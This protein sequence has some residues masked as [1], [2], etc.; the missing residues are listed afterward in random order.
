MALDIV[1][2]E[3]FVVV[4]KGRGYY[5]DKTWFIEQFLQ[6]RNDPEFFRVPHR[7]TLFTRPRR[8]GKT[9]F[10]SMLAAFFDRKMESQ[11][12]ELFA[13]LKVMS[14]ERLCQEWMNKY[15]VLFL[16]MKR[17]GKPTFSESMK[18]LKK[19]ISEV[20]RLHAA[21]VLE[22]QAVDSEDKKS[23]QKLCDKT[24]E[25]NDL[26]D[27]P[28]LLTKIL[29]AHHGKK[30][31]LLI[32]EYDDPLSKSFYHKYYNE[33]LPIMQSFYGTV[34]KG[35][36]HLNF[37]IITGILRVGIES[38][39]SDANNVTNYDIA[40]KTK[41]DDL[42]GFN[43]QEVDDVLAGAGL[44]DRRDE[45][46]TWYDGYHFGKREDIYCP[47]SVMSCAEDMQTVPELEPDDYWVN[48]SKN[49]ILKGFAGHVP[50]NI[51]KHMQALME[52]K[53]ISASINQSMDYD[54][55]N[56][57]IDNFW[58]L[59]FLT[60][61]L[62]GSNDIE[63][64]YNEH[65]KGNTLLAI[66]N[67]EVYSAFEREIKKW[68]GQ[69]LKSDDQKEFLRKFWAGDAQGLEK[70]L[71][72]KLMQSASFRDY[73][74]KE[75]FYHALLLGAFM[76][77]YRVVSNREAGEGVFD[78]M[79]E[80]NKCG[81]IIE[82][83]RGEEKENLESKVQEALEQIEVRNY[84]MELRAKGCEKIAHWGMAFS[85]KTCKVAVKYA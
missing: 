31:I 28:F 43:Q 20:S 50:L 67:K 44:V 66:P 7:A 17:V 25:Y 77:D 39:F 10:L 63:H 19:L 49:H 11:G 13:G 76:F 23:F 22:S 80:D 68:F 4:R 71:S 61:Y 55:V 40:K 83:K 51:L 41:Y 3:D 54:E 30:T 62:T 81:A 8:F 60:G 15:P 64:C 27:A 16:N 33:M 46:R 69:F 35:N 48:T 34:L 57:S 52:G 84:D 29:S 18:S 65:L 26:M 82:I 36:E 37:A 14:N 6:S 47:L 75:G 2:D 53:T 12:R 9:Q 73:K 85:K 79:V 24:A 74:D 21:E 58:T 42:F 1:L 78:L 56:V 45:I 38:L 72:D 59:L 5:V 70:L 32:D